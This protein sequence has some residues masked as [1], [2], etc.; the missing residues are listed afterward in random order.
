MKRE[1]WQYR[2]TGW[3]LWQNYQIAI[4]GLSQNENAD[5]MIGCRRPCILVWNSKPVQKIRR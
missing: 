5:H 4:E 3:N 1:G 2:D